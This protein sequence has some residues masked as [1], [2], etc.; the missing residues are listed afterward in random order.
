MSEN[1]YQSPSAETLDLQAPVKNT[2]LK[3]K[4]F[5]FQGRFSRSQYWGYGYGVPLLI[6]FLAIIPLIPLFI[7]L[8]G[9]DP[10][11]FLLLLLILVSVI[12]Y[13][14]AVWISIAGTAKRFHDRGKS[15]WMVLI[16]LIPY[17]GGFWILIE[18]GCMRGTIGS[19]LHGPDPLNE[20]H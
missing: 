12:I 15:G 9:H 8:N 10:S 11:L 16:A 6:S 1:L 5:S 2:T 3:E 7:I 13:I 14:P 19:N 18:C 4:L 17:V 20:L